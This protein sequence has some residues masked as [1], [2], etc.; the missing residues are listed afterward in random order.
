MVVLLDLDE[1]DVD[2]PS[3]DERYRRQHLQGETLE[4]VQATSALE[5]DRVNPN[6]GGFSAAL[7]C[8]PYVCQKYVT[9]SYAEVI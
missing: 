3:I 5:D 6:V 8:Y 1:N 4:A 2:K 7:A 9:R